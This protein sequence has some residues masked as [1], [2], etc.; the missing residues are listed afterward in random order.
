LEKEKGARA[1]EA[2]VDAYEFRKIA[3]HELKDKKY[4]AKWD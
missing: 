2:A 4:V 3:R 1:L